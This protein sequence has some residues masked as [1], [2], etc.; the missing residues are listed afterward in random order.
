METDVKNLWIEDLRNPANKQGCGRL[1]KLDE[2]DV[3]YDC[4]L[5]RLC[6]LAI[7]S[8]VNVTV[9]TCEVSGLNRKYY[10][11][12]NTAST[13]PEIV[14]GWA[15]LNDYDP[16]ITVSDITSEEIR[17]KIKKKLSQRSVVR[18][19]RLNDDVELTFSEIAD[20]IEDCL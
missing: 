5:G 12:D 16:A 9:K 2:L 4:C 19:S 15:G 7:D 13:L 10:V 20:V 6:Q 1:T 3:R 11:Y 17:E 14:V 8:G 18:L